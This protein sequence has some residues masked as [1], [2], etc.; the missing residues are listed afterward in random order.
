MEAHA[1]NAPAQTSP[2][3]SL[4][5]FIT[6]LSKIIDPLTKYGSLFAGFVLA[7]MMFLTFFDVSGRFLFKKPVL[8]SFEITVFLM[9]LMVSF[10]LAYCAQ[11]KGHIR[12]DVIM[13][14]VSAK[15]NAWLDIFAYGLS[16]IF[17]ILIASQVF[18]NA[19]EVIKTQLTSSVLYI[20]IYPFVFVLV[21]GAALVA[22]VLFRDF[23]NSIKEVTK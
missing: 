7:A 4:E 6:L 3:T 20:P 17:Y 19:L 11:H 14:F 2:T 15:A 13:Q 23:L 5:K 9:S 1:K 21:F 10:A 12:V 22:L 8:G 16:F 18:L